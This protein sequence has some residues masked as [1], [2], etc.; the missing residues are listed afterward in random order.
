MKQQKKKNREL[1]VLIRITPI[2]IS[3]TFIEQKGPHFQELYSKRYQAFPHGEF[4]LEK[5]EIHQFS[6]ILSLLRSV[7]EEVMFFIEKERKGELKSHVHIIFEEPYTYTHTYDFSFDDELFPIKGEFHSFLEKRILDNFSREEHMDILSLQEISFLL[8]GHEVE[9]RVWNK[10]IKNGEHSLRALVSFIDRD[11]F[12][13][14]QEEV[15]W[16]FS[17][18]FFDVHFHSRSELFGKIASSLSKRVD[19]GFHI[20]DIASYSTN[21]VSHPKSSPISFSSFPEGGLT[22]LHAIARKS[23]LPLSKIRKIFLTANH[24]DFHQDFQDTLSLSTQEV[25]SEWERL[26]YLHMKSILN[27]GEI[28]PNLFVFS[29]I[30]SLEEKVI[31]SIQEAD[32]LDAL[33]PKREGL[34]AVSLVGKVL[35]GKGDKT[36]KSVS[37]HHLPFLIA[38]HPEKILYETEKKKNK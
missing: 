3:L 36:R 34:K 14:I 4:L 31:S 12:E 18:P 37:H 24:D 22:I 20:I 21:V 7:F 19:G 8:N 26:L 23:S 11:F 27:A 5:R 10:D 28:S 15:K 25:L 1:E 9:R 13:R 30:L 29:E 32:F 38:L 35:S 16:F 2:G 6:H 33:F 17:S